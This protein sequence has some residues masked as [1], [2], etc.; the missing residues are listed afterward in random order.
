MNSKWVWIALAGGAAISFA[1]GR[2][3]RPAGYSE[4][5]AATL[6][7]V[8]HNALGL[9]PVRDPMM[10]SMGYAFIPARSYAP[11]TVATIPGSGGLHR[12]GYG[13]AD[14]TDELTY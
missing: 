14:L 2:R 8:T 3:R 10:A 9:A 12:G 6:S 4:L 13:P 7:G 11:A 5:P 1:L